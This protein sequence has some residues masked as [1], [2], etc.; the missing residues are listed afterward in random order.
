MEEIHLVYPYYELQLDEKYFGTILSFVSLSV[1]EKE[2]VKNAEPLIVAAAQDMMP[3]EYYDKKAKQFKGIN[4]DYFNSL[5]KVTGLK[6][7]FTKRGSRNEL[8]EKLTS[9]EIDLM[10]S[11]DYNSKVAAVYNVLM[12]SPYYNN[13]L[14][15]VVRN[16]KSNTMNTSSVAVVEEDFPIYEF[17]MREKGYTSINYCKSLKECIKQIQKG[18]ADIT[19]IPSSSYDSLNDNYIFDKIK[20]YPLTNDSFKFSIGVSKTLDPIIVDILDKGIASIT[21]QQKNTILMNNMSSSTGVTSFKEFVLQ[22][23]TSLFVF[24]LVVMAVIMLVIARVIIWKNKNTKELQNAISKADRAN[25]A[26]TEFLARMSH[27]MRTPMNGIIGLIDLLEEENNVEKIHSSLKQMKISSM[28]L[29]SLI[30]DTL[31][32]N[33]IEIG[34]L[35]LRKQ[36]CDR[37]ELLENVYS[38]LLIMANEKKHNYRKK[39]S[40]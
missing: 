3:M 18:K 39:I 16:N 2:F 36:P 6:F 37:K 28:F 21:T 26:K 13:S 15:F 22:H 10:S 12:T 19:V 20:S 5:L 30:N 1:D 33:R 29:L 27:D 8:R 38:N 35:E 14:A 4:I 25:N 24:I 40:F 17:I 9:G 34:K 23:K 32:M 31:D 7:V 11:V